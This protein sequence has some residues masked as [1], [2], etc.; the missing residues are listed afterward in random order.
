M[1]D[2]IP[3]NLQ[4]KKL[5]EMEKE[6]VCCCVNRDLAFGALPSVQDTYGSTVTLWGGG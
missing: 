4:E 2:L 1:K 5:E 6:N 3:L